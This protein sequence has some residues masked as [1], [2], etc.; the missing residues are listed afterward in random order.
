MTRI[1]VHPKNAA[2][3]LAILTLSKYPLDKVDFSIDDYGDL[4]FELNQYDLPD[5]AENHDAYTRRF[6]R[7][8]LAIQSL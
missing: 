1:T 4:Q 6:F 5:Y 7:M 2:N 3:V 8:I